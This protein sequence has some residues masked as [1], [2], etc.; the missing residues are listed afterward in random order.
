[1]FIFK[2]YPALFQERPLK[3]TRGI[4][5]NM[6][7]WVPNKRL[8]DDVCAKS[9]KVAIFSWNFDCVHL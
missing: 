5:K 6:A 9:P 1:M 2:N 3:Q 8:G 7:I 4:D